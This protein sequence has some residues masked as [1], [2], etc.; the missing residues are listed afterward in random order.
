MKY[1]PVIIGTIFLLLLGHRAMYAQVYGSNTFEFQYGNLPYENNRDLTT[2]YDQLNLYYDFTHISLYGRL[3]QFI[4]P[5]RQ[6]NYFDLT[7]K[8]LQYEDEHIKIRLGNFYESLGRGLLLRSYEI[9]GSVFENDFYRTRYAFNRDLEGV[10]INYT[11][12]LVEAKAMYA[13]PLFNL[14]PPNFEPDSMRRPDLVQALEADFFVSDNLSVGGIFLRFKNDL[15]GEFREYASLKFNSNLPSNVQLTGEYAFRTDT[16]PAFFTFSSADSYGFYTGLNYF[17]NRFGASL[18]Y[19][20][21]NRITLGSGF[22]NPPSL[23]KEHTYPVLNR[24]T[25][26][27]STSDETGIQFEAYYTFEGGHSMTVNYTRAKNEVA[28]RFRYEEYFI[29]SSYNVNEMLT[30]KSFFDY[31]N[32][33]LKGEEDRVSAGIIAEKIFNYEWSATL[34]L[35]F[36]RFDRSF[37]EKTS[38]NYFA[39]LSVNIIPDIT[40]GTVFEASTDP[41]LTDDPRTLEIETETRTWL[42]V[43]L[44]YEIN[45]S[46]T[47]EL[48]VG[49]RRGGPA[50]TSGICYEILD[51]EGAELRFITRF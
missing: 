12:D 20:N 2:A 19:K 3:E 23:I 45:T 46:H 38:K 18:E 41:N 30:V 28:N 24:S 35:Q 50:C 31:A 8:R 47:L 14:L 11:G 5:F 42:G 43:N 1:L 32:D 13:R 37:N 25:H 10:A 6:R 51:F 33:D 40:L 22:N 27:L 34:D 26:V 7:Q 4:T 15:S 48:F 16:N 44:R 39:S 21:Y 9:P 29:E 49:K 17:H 36:Q